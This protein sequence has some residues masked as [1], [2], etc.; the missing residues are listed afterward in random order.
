MSELNVKIVELPPMRVA[1]VH[2]FGTS[3][4]LLAWDKL[5]K[6]VDAMGYRD[7]PEKHRIFGFNNPDPSAGSPNYGYELWIEIGEDEVQGEE[8][9][10][11]DFGGGLYAVARCEVVNGNYDVIGKTWKALVAWR[12]GSKYACGNHQWLE[13][14]Y[15]V[16]DQ[17]DGNFTLDLCLPIRE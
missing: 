5:Y 4:E 3:P 9:T 2:G 13:E 17:E 1:S 10:A 7:A 12:E 11:K 16:G 6:F 8:V 15:I 14:S